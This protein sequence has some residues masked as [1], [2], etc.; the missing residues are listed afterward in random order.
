MPSATA[1][2]RI[3]RGALCDTLTVLGPDAPTLCEGWTTRDLAAHLRLRE[4]RP[5][6][7][8]GIAV[9]LLA[10]HTRRVQERTAA[11]PYADLVRSL[12]DGPPLLSV[13][14]VPGGQ[15]LPTLLEFLIHHED[16]RRA[17][18][19]WV[20]RE[21]PAG[22]EPAVA[23][24]LA[25]LGKAFY[26][27]ARVGVVLRFP[28]GRDVR[29]RPGE[30]SVTVTGAPLEQLLYAFGRKEQ[31]QVQVDGDPAVVRDFARTP[32]GA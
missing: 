18:P 2:A 12:R 7:L 24:M 14:R 8:P 21:L 25:R 9:P 29:V 27:K 1:L 3:E 22:T 4:T 19:G 30:P 20:P 17:Q 28:D 23:G 6:A 11:A 31:A 32:L 5:D 16:A 10:G 13:W 15:G 26:R